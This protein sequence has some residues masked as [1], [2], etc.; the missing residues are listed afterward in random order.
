[1]QDYGWGGAAGAF[2]GIIP[3][4]DVS[5][6]HVQHVLNAPNALTRKALTKT[7]LQDL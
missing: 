6:F 2:L 7:I 3:P 4:V 5:F 1:M